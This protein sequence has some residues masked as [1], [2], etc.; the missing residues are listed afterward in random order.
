MGGLDLVEVVNL[1]SSG[2]T[3]AIVAV[4]THVT[5]IAQT[6]MATLVTPLAEQVEVGNMHSQT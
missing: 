2:G 3:G 6:T 5:P 1:E 4:G